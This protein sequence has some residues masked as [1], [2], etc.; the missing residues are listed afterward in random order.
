M[1]YPTL[2]VPIRHEIRTNLTITDRQGLTVSL[3]ERG[4]RLDKARS[5]PAREGRAKAPA[6]ALPG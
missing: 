2:A 3:N 5:R 1:D 6:T 4:P